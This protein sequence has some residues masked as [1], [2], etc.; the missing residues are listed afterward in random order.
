MHSETLCEFVKALFQILPCSERDAFYLVHSN[1]VISFWRAFVQN[2]KDRF[3]ADLTYDQVSYNDA[4]R[5]FSKNRIFG[6]QICPTTESNLALLFNS[7]KLV[8]YQLVN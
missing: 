6:A 1:G 5:F 2:H 8:F 4:Q 3:S 7:G